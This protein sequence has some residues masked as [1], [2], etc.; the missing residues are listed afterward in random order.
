LNR[1]LSS[2][3]DKG[4]CGQDLASCEIS[5]QRGYLACK[6]AESRSAGVGEQVAGKDELVS[7][8]WPGRTEIQLGLLCVV[9][10]KA[11][12]G[13]T[14]D[15][16]VGGRR[17]AHTVQRGQQQAA[18]NAMIVAAIVLREMFTELSPQ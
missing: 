4:A 6:L 18:R 8:A 7:W 10:E 3:E 1:D 16:F 14:V 17:S 2:I 13:D 5:T 15:G 9:A 12:D 11:K